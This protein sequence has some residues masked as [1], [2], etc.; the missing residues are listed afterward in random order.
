M[1]Q[2]QIR[3]VV[4]A[5][6]GAAGW[7]AAAAL[8]RVLKD[9]Y[10]TITLVESSEIGIVGVGEATI[11]TIHLYNQLL[12]LNE[13][14]FIRAT[15]A[16]FKLGIE[17][18][19]WCQPGQRY[20]HPFG[21]CGVPLEVSDFQHFWLRLRAAGDST[22]I[23]EYSLSAVA[24]RLGRFQRPG[25][26][27]RSVLAMLAYAFH[28]DAGH[29]AAYLREYA[30]RRGVRRI[31]ERIAE[32]Q[33]RSEDG[34]IEALRLE[35]GERI[36]GDLFIDCTG[37][38]A[39]LIGEALQVG[40]EDWGHWLPCDRAVTVPCAS[41]TPLL[42]YTRATARAAGWQWRIPLQHRIGNGYVY[43][44]QHLG[45]AEAAQLL[46]ANLDGAALAEP[47]LLQFKAGRRLQCWHRNCVAL[48]LASGFLEPLESTSIHLIQN[49][50]LKLLRRFPDRHFDPLVSG[51]YNR[52]LQL[53]FE[54]MRDF[55]ILHYHANG[56][57]G[58]ALW[59]HCRNMS[60]P[61]TLRQKLENF[62]ADGR[63]IALGNELFQDN[64]WLAVLL[65]QGIE[66]RGYDPLVDLLPEA[67]I[68]RQLGGLRQHLRQAALQLPTHEEFIARHCKAEP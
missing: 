20:L 46:L 44:S 38:R 3:R 63:L 40:F 55:I 52:Q 8:A 7:M 18:V 30:L 51:E 34:F 59:D 29:Y 1:S 33:L 19:D 35:S 60:I 15:R 13:D 68:R 21:A 56:R 27:P 2:P 12:G 26:D 67:E 64:S 5:G 61:D 32:V 58:E 43:S 47:R 10:C 17:F 42:P 66:P 39:L 50:I 22:P 53:D 6:G 14:E 24:A 48:G 11:P 31:D 65:G 45:D 37:F 41:A 23:G 49:G 57:A 36:E 4:I 28:F 62:R 9:N 54:R 25:T 16:S